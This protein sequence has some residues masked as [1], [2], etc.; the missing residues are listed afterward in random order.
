MLSTGLRVRREMS[1]SYAGQPSNDLLLT[2]VV[3]QG[4]I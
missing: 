3:R 4:T 1:K 2:T